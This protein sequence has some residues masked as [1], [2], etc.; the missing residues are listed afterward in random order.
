M[1]SEGV[2]KITLT[3]TAIPM[4]MLAK[5]LGKVFDTA[6]GRLFDQGGNATP[7][8]STLSFRSLKSNGKFKYFQYLK[9]K[10]S[11]PNDEAATKETKVTPKP[12]KIIFTA[13]NTVHEFNLG[14]VTKSVKRIVG[15]EDTT[16]FSG[17]G[18][19]TQVQ[20]PSITTPAAVAL[21]SS[22]PTNSATG[23]SKTNAFTLTFN[24]AMHSLVINH[25]A[26]LDASN[27]L[28]SVTCTLDAT[29]KIITVNHGTLAGSA[30]HTLVIAGAIDI[31][32][33]VLANT[34]VKFTTAA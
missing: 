2:T 24:N 31:Y 3:T 12:A 21:S 6:S 17:T 25:V 9:G 18:F 15:D 13:I 7:P 29:K 10:F 8:D 32:G 14:T 22:V 20:V 5:Y 16:N 11:V 26:L 4:E 34:L 28:V 27:T 1:T 30:A 23:V 19:F 33:Q